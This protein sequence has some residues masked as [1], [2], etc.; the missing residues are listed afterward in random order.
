M[1]LTTDQVTALREMHAEA[2]TAEDK[3]FQTHDLKAEAVAHGYGIG[4]RAT[5]ALLLGI[6]GADVELLLDGGDLPNVVG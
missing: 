5:L 2:L 3:G 1:K 4:M 6:D